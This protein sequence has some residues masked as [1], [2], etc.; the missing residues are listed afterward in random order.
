[1]ASVEA[2]PGRCVIR[3]RDEGPGIPPALLSTVFEPFS[4]AD[5]SRSR[6]DARQGGSGLGLAV[7]AA[8]TAAHGGRIE[9]DSV[10]GRTE[11]TVELPTADST[12]RAPR[13]DPVTEVAA[14]CS[15]RS[16]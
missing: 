7:A 8:I 16:R 12:A 5:T 3:V 14:A 6:A 11:F 2:M 9:V 4:R 15:F 1:V 10:P 13:A